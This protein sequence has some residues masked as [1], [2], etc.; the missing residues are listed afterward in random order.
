MKKILLAALAAMFV[1]T[2]PGCAL[3]GRGGA[4]EFSPAESCAYIKK[5]GS[6]QW[7]SV[8]TAEQGDYSEEELAAYAKERISAFNSALGKEASAENKSGQEKLPAAFVSCRLD[9]KKAV[10]I[11]EYD[12]PARL[13]EFA[14]EI[15]DYNVGFT[16]LETGSPED[17]AGACGDPEMVDTRGKAVEDPLAAAQKA[18]SSVAVAAEGQ[19]IIETERKILYVSQGCTLLSEHRVQTADKAVS[20]IVLE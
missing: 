12:T 5:D 20:C 7:A 10:L 6:L 14:E 17:I 3:S 4:V 1:L 18:G 13:I 16:L 8:E 11:T 9:D 2:L 15:G 19:G